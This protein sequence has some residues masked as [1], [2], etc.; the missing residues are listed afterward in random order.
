MKPNSISRE[1]SDKIVTQFRRGS[2]PSKISQRTGIPTAEVSAE[3]KRRGLLLPKPRPAEFVLKAV[4]AWCIERLTSAAAHRGIMDAATLAA[5]IL[6]G[7]LS[8]GSISDDIR[9]I[10]THHPKFLRDEREV[11]DLIEFT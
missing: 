11:S 2:K 8:R 4:P 7:R 10:G 6:I 9:G 5:L 3:L 1:V